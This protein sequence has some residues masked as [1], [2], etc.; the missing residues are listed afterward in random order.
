MRST[1]AALMLALLAPCAALAQASESVLE[2]PRLAPVRAQLERAVAAARAE[3]LPDE[4]LLDKMA[5][6]LSKRVPPPRIAAA[7]DA[8][9]GRIRTADAMIRAVPGA[10]GAERRRLVRAAAD[11]LAAGAPDE[12]LARLVRDVARDRANAVARVQEV[13]TTVAEL[14]ERDFGGEAAVAATGDAW[15]RRRA[16]GLRE[17]LAGARRI[18]PAPR[19]DRDLALRGVGREIGSSQSGIDRSGP[20]RDDGPDAPR[21]ANPR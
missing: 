8:L 19:S 17:L 20:R 2:D 5:E 1:A 3:N 11:A 9:L 14:A 21:G 13:L 6:G 7:V 4:W 16:D 18:G 12:A 15:R 10:R